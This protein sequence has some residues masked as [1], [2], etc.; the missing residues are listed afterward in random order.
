M[1]TPSQPLPRA[2][3]A[4]ARQIPADGAVTLRFAFPDDAGSIARLAALDSS[5]PPL[6][7]VLIAE[8][9]GELRAGLS[10]TDGAVI[11]DPFHPT[12]SLV[13]L[14]IARATQ[15]TGT[16]VIAVHTLR[17]QFRRP[18]LAALGRADRA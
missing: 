9:A 7:P 10:L 5:E 14:L 12:V 2:P 15:L 1:R 13:E 3:L 18:R 11:A 17:A 6:G 4:Q 16:R 8:V